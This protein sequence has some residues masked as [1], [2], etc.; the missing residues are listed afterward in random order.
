[1]DYFSLRGRSDLPFQIFIGPR[2]VGKTYSALDI[3]LDSDVC[4]MYLRRT[5][6]EADMAMSNYTNPYKRIA[7]DKGIDI[8]ADKDTGI[9]NIGVFKQRLVDKS[10]D[11]FV[12]YAASLTGFANVRGADFSDVTH[13]I[14]DECVPE[15]HKHKIK[16]EGKAFLNLY[17]S[18]N[19]NRELNGEQPVICY[20]LCNSINL[21]S[22]LF[23]ELRVISIVEHM[24][25]HN[26]LR[27]SDRLRG[28]YVELVQS[29][30]SL[31]K[32]N[33][34]LYRLVG[35]STY[36]NEALKNQFTNND[37]SL[38]AK[39]KLKE[40]VPYITIRSQSIS[41]TMYT[42][43]SLYRYHISASNIKQGAISIND[44]SA[45]RRAIKQMYKLALSD[46]AI[47][48]DSLATKTVIDSLLN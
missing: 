30:V 7:K 6:V 5:A 29:E 14:Y 22:D 35:D 38:I 25:R 40:Y 24:L 39:A 10:D 42:H 21:C 19:R 32:D 26:I 3:S 12:A 36:R 31:A 16:H 43:K 37:L 9:K 41:Y 48:F 44:V 11:V 28:V 27:Y 13:I 46:K 2:G 4:A 17:E 18:I 8:V 15:L 23:A 47:T 1:M 20:M 33:T 34:A 45:I